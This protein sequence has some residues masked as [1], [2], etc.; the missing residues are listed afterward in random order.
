MIRGNVAEVIVK[1]MK[2]PRSALCKTSIMAST[3]IFHSFG[4]LLL[5]TTEDNAIDQLVLLLCIP[6]CRNF[7]NNV[8]A[9]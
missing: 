1:A 6:F 2:S 3:D 4:H 7:S 8:K 9:Y 5:S